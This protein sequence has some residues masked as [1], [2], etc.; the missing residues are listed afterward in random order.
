MCRQVAENSAG[1]SS[2]ETSQFGK[3]QSSK[4]LNLLQGFIVTFPNRDNKLLQVVRRQPKIHVP[5]T[6]IGEVQKTFEFSA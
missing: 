1:I 6:P 3:S 2:L 5:G 4:R